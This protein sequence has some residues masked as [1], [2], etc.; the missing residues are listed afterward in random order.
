LKAKAFVY[1]RRR[2]AFLSAEVSLLDPLPEPNPN[3]GKKTERARKGQSDS[4]D[5]RSGSKVPAF[6]RENGSSGWIR[7]NNPPVNRLMQVMYLIGS[8]VV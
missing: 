3:K 1:A 2:P 8:S 5:S 7:T 4:N 6:V